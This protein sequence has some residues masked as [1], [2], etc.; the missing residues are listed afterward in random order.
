MER[1]EPDLGEA[2]RQKTSPPQ[3]S[4]KLVDQPG[5]LAA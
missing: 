5:N 1:L 3:S 4:L 2:L